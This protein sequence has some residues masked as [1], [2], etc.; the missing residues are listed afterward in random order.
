MIEGFG[1][2]LLARK[3]NWGNDGLV[4]STIFTLNYCYNQFYSNQLVMGGFM[5]IGEVNRDNYKQFLKLF[6]VKNDKVMAA[7]MGEDKKEYSEEETIARLI[8]MGLIEE[9]MITKSGEGGDWRKTVPVSDEVRDKII[10]TVRRQFLENG[11]GMSKPGGVDGGEIGAIMKEY[12]KNIPPNERLAVTW[13]L[14]QIHINEQKR[15]VNY[16]KS[17]DPTWNHGQKFDKNILLNSNFG[18]DSVD[19]RG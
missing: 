4:G 11:N 17:Q 7:V 16:I 2:F 18:E 19:V 1:W 6:G 15:L 5:R 14:S 13:T 10:A 9:G 8:K 12:R 3:L